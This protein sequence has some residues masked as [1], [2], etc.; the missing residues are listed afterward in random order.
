MSWKRRRAEILELRFCKNSKLIK[1]QQPQVETSLVLNILKY[2]NTIFP[3]NIEIYCVESFHW[4]LTKGWFPHRWKPALCYINIFEIYLAH[5]L[6]FKL[7][8]FFVKTPHRLSLTNQKWKSA[9]CVNT[10][11]Q[12]YIWNISCSPSEVLV[13][14]YICKKLHT[15]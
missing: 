15:G 14:K 1:P 6:K 12:I 13:F 8:I 2:F 3:D 4:K 11:D 5:H 9:L 7:W 10:F